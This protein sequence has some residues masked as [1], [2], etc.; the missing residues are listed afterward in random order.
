MIVF[1]LFKVIFIHIL[2][3]TTSN[4]IQISRKLVTEKNPETPV[5]PQTTRGMVIDAGSGGSRLHIFRWAPRVFTQI[6]PGITVPTSDEKWTQVS[7]HFFYPNKIIIIII[8]III[9]VII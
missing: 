5:S 3:Y 8:I 6:P 7:N 1:K 2:S 4:S 9:I